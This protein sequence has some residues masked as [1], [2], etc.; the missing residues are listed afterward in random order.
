MLSAHDVRDCYQGFGSKTVWPL[1]HYFPLSTSYEDRYWEAFVRVN[2]AFSSV[3]AQHARP[4]DRIWIHDYQLML[5]PGLVRKKCPD[6]SIG[7]FLHIP[8]PSFELFRLLPW[9]E[10]M[11]I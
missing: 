11:G 7:F 4:G 6:V 3:V 2:E 9:R 8:F 5:L 10:D 1:F